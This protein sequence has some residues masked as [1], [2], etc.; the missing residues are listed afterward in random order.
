MPYRLEIPEEILMFVKDSLQLKNHK[1]IKD[2][3]FYPHSINNLIKL[4]WLVEVKEPMS[5]VEAWNSR[6]PMHDVNTSPTL[7]FKQGWKMGRENLF[8]EQKQHIA[9]SI[10]SSLSDGLNEIHAK[11]VT[12]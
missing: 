3:D 10:A 2:K 4:G 8:L 5:C 1:I 6:A 12:Y 9:N 11:K 7:D